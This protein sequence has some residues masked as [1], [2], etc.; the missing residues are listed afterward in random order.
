[1]TGQE[2]ADS[3]WHALIPISS[4]K[5]GWDLK[6]GLSARDDSLSNAKSVGSWIRE[7]RELVSLDRPEV[8]IGK[9]G[10]VYIKVGVGGRHVILRLVGDDA[11]LFLK[12]IKN[13]KDEGDST[14]EGRCE[15][16]DRNAIME[17]IE[18]TQQA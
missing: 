5:Y 7:L 6:G 3:I 9:D 8:E 12:V 1:M 2:A 17:L 13:T 11:C 14:I 10:T 4:L 16:S 15:A 18:W